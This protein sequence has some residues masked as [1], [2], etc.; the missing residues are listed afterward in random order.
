MRIC[1]DAYWW[2]TGPPSGKNVVKS[3]CHEWKEQFPNDA[4][5]LFTNS[6][7]P[8]LPQN[9]ETYR[10]RLRPHGISN[11]FEIPVVGRKCDALLVQNFTP[12][13][14][15][16]PTVTYV[17]D[18]IFRREPQWF[19]WSERTYLKLMM[20]TLGRSSNS[21]IVTS[22]TS[23]ASHVRQAIKGRRSVTPVGLGLP[24]SFLEAKATKPQNA[25]LDSPFLLTVGRLNIRKNITALAQELASKSHIYGERTLVIAG[26]VDGR[27][28]DLDLLKPYLA[29][30]RTVLLGHVTDG[31]L[32][33]LYSNCQQF[34]FPSLDEGFGLPILEAA[35]SGCAL[36][37]SDI[38]PFREV[39]PDTAKFF[40]PI[41]FSGLSES[42]Q[43]LPASSGANASGHDWALVVRKIRQEIKDGMARRCRS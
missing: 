21:I 12:F 30:G 31:E 25:A 29:S 18:V 5:V 39:A 2:D 42:L 23:E 35:A 43:A 28:P 41:T 24:A 16:R 19:T 40:D 26:G 34:V 13:W 38:P 6:H 37:L 8:D 22:S 27:T 20:L 11:L 7:A 32:K 1:I 10:P 9:C 36:A 33:W 4:V 15:P 17:H 14:C 3:L